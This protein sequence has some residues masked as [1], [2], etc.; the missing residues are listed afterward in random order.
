MRIDDWA[1]LQEL[2]R[3]WL[4][5]GRKAVKVDAKTRATMIAAS[6]LDTGKVGI[7]GSGLRNRD[8]YKESCEDFGARL[9]AGH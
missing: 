2:T 7:I 1:P 6:L 9:R 8:D 4:Y 3:Q 5:P